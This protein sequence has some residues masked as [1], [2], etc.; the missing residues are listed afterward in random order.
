MVH[1]GRKPKA[2]R[3]IMDCRIPFLA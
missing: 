3:I 1:V 2:D